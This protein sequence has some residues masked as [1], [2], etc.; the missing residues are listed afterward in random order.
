[1]NYINIGLL[2]H[3]RLDHKQYREL[4]VIINLYPPPPLPFRWESDPHCPRISSYSIEESLQHLLI[5]LYL[6]DPPGGHCRYDGLES[7][8][9]QTSEMAYMCPG[10]PPV[11]ERHSSAGRHSLLTPCRS[12]FT[13]VECALFCFQVYHV[14]NDLTC[15]LLGATR[16]RPTWCEME[17][18]LVICLRRNEWFKYQHM[19]KFQF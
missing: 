8:Q 19:V 1:M 13:Q 3:C 9:L 16:H 5:I 6:R 7:E 15:N 10:C 18:H 2:W 11:L 17:K 12:G 14:C 4:Q